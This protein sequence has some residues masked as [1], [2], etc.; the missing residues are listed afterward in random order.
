MTKNQ[1]GDK[2]QWVEK[3]VPLMELKPYE[4]NPRQISKIQFEKLKESIEQDGYHSRIKCTSDFK[5][6]GGHQRLKAMLELGY[7]EVKVLI[8][9]REI[10]DETFRRVLI[11]DNHNNGLFDMD[12]LANVFDLEE[13]RDFGLH[14][15]MNIA[16]EDTGEPP[17]PP[18]TMV[19][20]PH[21]QHEFPAKGN[22]VT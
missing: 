12:A 20:C 10:D 19:R 6:V 17:P 22:K 7:T 21:C 1:Q 4:A 18:K 15:V 16:P 13:L 5:V 8:P 9:D 3:T 2:I 14:E 11:R